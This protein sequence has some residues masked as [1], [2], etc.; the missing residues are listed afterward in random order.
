MSLTLEIGAKYPEITG[1]VSDVFNEYIESICR[2]GGF[3]ELVLDLNGTR[4]ISSM[5]MGSIFAAHQ[6]LNS[7]GKTL[8]IINASEK[9]THL[10]RMVNLADVLL[11]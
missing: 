6:R 10:L 9:V 11:Q 5:A 8:R 1:P 2:E 3:S 7:Q 4:M